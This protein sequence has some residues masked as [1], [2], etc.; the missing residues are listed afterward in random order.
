MN[1]VAIVCSSGNNRGI[2]R[3]STGLGSLI[4]NVRMV[5]YSGSKWIVL[6][7]MIGICMERS[8]LKGA[9]TIIFANTRISPLLSITLGYTRV[10]IVVHDLMD[11]VWDKRPGGSKGFGKSFAILGN[12]VVM[13][14]SI[15][16][17]QSIIVNSNV[18]KRDLRR[19]GL[20]NNRNVHVIYPRPT[21]RQD[22]VCELKID[23][24]QEAEDEFAVLVVTGK[25][26]NKNRGGYYELARVLFEVHGIKP[27]FDIVGNTMEDCTVEE[28]NLITSDRVRVNLLGKVD[29]SELLTLYLEASVFC[30]LSSNEGFGIPLDDALGFGIDCVTSNI[31]AYKEVSDLHEEK[32]HVMVDSISKVAGLLA[33]SY[34]RHSRMPNRRQHSLRMNRYIGHCK[35]RDTLI[36]RQLRYLGLR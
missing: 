32:A 14:F 19:K 22:I 26:E 15:W 36:K 25:S 7:E 24:S 35:K 17:A 6:W 16:R 29:D 28:V 33:V 27:R 18:T 8:V 34:E 20:L 12:T 1:R 30:S 23:D 5:V 2:H 4:E 11:T 31:D 10:I 9:D 3:Y 13:F 21:F